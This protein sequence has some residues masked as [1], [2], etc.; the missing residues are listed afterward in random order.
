MCP[1]GLCYGLEENFP[2]PFQSDGHC[3][4][5]RIRNQLYRFAWVLVAGDSSKL[6]SETS[7]TL[8][9]VGNL[10]LPDRNQS[11]FALLRNRVNEMNEEYFTLTPSLNLGSC[12]GVYPIG[13]LGR[14]VKSGFLHWASVA[15][16][17]L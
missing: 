15:G 9:P 3:G 16:L 10:A 4:R 2:M 14:R 13:S 11:I 17:S 12:A 6:P 5:G 8:A 1:Y 7:E